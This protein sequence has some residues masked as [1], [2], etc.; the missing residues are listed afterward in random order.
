MKKIIFWGTPEFS[1]PSLQALHELDLVKAVVTMPDRPSGRNQKLTA[2]PVKIFALKNNIPVITD[3]LSDLKKYLPAV[4]VIVAYGKIISQ[5]IL[6]LSELPSL[7]I[8]PSLLPNLRGPSPIQTALLKG[9]DKTGVTLMQLDHKM[10]HG[11]IL[12][13]IEAK[14]DP[15]QG[16]VAL[17]GQLADLGAKLLQNS[18]LDYLQNKLTVR[19]QDDSQATFCQLIKKSDGQ[20]DFTKSALDIHNQVRAFEDWPTSFTKFGDLEVKIIKTKI[21]NTKLA[22]GQLKIENNK[23][24]VGCKDQSLEILEIQPAGK[25]I[26][27]GDEFIRGYSKSLT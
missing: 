9:Q 24:L 15:N 7:N 2:T 20:I 16:F 19:A 17:S 18:I 3:N 21:N 1:L 8:H 4:F 6:D 11:P 13:Q 25:K 23:L 12:G 5:E 14:I 27:T 10:D 22:V 26:M